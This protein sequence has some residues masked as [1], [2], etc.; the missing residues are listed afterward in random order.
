MEEIV[1]LSRTFPDAREDRE[2]PVRLCDVMDKLHDDDGLADART[3]E[4]ADFTALQKRADE[5]DGLDARFEDFGARALFEKARGVSVDWQLFAACGDSAALVYGVARYVED[6]SECGRAD[7]HFYRGAGVFDAVAA[8]QT[9]GR[10]HRNGSDY[11][12]AELLLDFEHDF[13]AV[14]AR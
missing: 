10:C 4:C 8:A 12:S 13:R 1:A 6:S 11:A 2:A 7:G 9:F 5:V 3:A 14:A